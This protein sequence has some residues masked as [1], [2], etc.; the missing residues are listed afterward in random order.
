MMIKWVSGN[1][2]IPDYGE[3]IEGREVEMEDEKA[4]SFIKQGLAELVKPVK[5]VKEEVK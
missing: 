4:R 1:R 5:S 3:M 2:F